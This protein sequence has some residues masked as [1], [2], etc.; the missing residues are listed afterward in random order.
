MALTIFSTG[1][2]RSATNRP[3]PGTDPGS[4]AAG[5]FAVLSRDTAGSCGRGNDGAQ[6]FAALYR[7]AIRLWRAGRGRRAFLLAPSTWPLSWAHKPF[8]VFRHPGQE[9]AGKFRDRPG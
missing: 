9:T 6:P 1:H 8:R 5:S 3:Y 7:K 4:F 2:R